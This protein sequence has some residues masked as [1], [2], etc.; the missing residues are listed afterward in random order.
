M[1]NEAKIQLL[2][3]LKPSFAPSAKSVDLQRCNPIH[4][5]Q[6]PKKPN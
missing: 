5:G 3:N 4:L 2:F 1:H 6:L